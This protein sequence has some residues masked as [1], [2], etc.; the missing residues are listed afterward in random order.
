[1]PLLSLSDT[2]V[3][4]LGEGH[5]LIFD[6]VLGD[7]G[8]TELRAFVDGISDNG[9]L[10][11][12]G[13]GRAGLHRADNAARDDFTTFIESGDAPASLNQLFE[14]IREEAN[15]AAWL[16][17]RR[18]DIQAA[19]YAANGA[20]YARHRD[21]FLGSDSRRLTAIYYLNAGWSPSDGGVLR[22]YVHGEVVDVEPQLDRLVLF[23][24][25][26]VEHEVMPSFAERFALTAWYCAR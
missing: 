15:Q 1:M 23:L 8:A 3:V 4:A 19:R 10:S 16:G 13:I 17:L 6:H 12:A 11:P 5:P 9:R 14:A 21:A 7:A 25:D 20:A 22:C 24:S 18:F 26:R 2:D